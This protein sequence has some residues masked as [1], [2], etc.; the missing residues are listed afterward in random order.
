MATTHRTPVHPG[1]RHGDGR[2][3][4]I[5]G[6]AVGSMLLFQLS[7]T[8]AVICLLVLGGAMGG[9]MMFRGWAPWRLRLVFLGTIIG[10]TLYVVFAWYGSSTGA[11]QIY[12]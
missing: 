2:P 9:M 5:F 8:L 6:G 12:S 4:L 1:R 3:Q 11:P 7:L 10:T